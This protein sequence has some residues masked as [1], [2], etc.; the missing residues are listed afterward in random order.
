MNKTI[1][2]KIEEIQRKLISNFAGLEPDGTYWGF[3][4][5]LGDCKEEINESTQSLLTLFQ[6]EIEE[7]KK[8]GAREMELKMITMDIPT[9]YTGTATNQEELSENMTKFI[10]EEIRK[11]KIAIKRLDSLLSP[12]PISN[13]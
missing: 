10:K 4:T 9:D 3:D 8:E 7:A 5:D 13:S 6:E 1:I 2:K 12:K 11:H